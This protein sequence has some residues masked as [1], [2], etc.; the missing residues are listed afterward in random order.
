MRVVT[1]E[2]RHLDLVPGARLDGAMLRDLVLDGVDLSGSSLRGTF[3]NESWLVGANLAGSDLSGA[4]FYGADLRG[5]DLSDCRLD[6][7][8]W[9]EATWSASTRWPD[10]SPPGPMTDPLSRE[11]LG[12]EC[13]EDDSGLPRFVLFDER[14]VLGTV[15]WPRSIAEGIAAG[16]RCTRADQAEVFFRMAYNVLAAL[17]LRS[18]LSGSPLIPGFM[19]GYRSPFMD[20][21]AVDDEPRWI[22]YELEAALG[23]CVLALAALGLRVVRANVDGSLD[24]TFEPVGDM[25]SWLRDGRF[26][27]FEVL[28]RRALDQQFGAPLGAWSEPVLEMDAEYLAELNLDS[29]FDADEDELEEADDEEVP[30]GELVDGPDDVDPDAPP[31]E[32]WSDLFFSEFLPW[33]TIREMVDH[34]HDDE[35]V[36]SSW[37]RV[38]EALGGGALAVDGDP[39]RS[40]RTVLAAYLRAASAWHQVDGLLSRLDEEDMSVVDDE[41]EDEDDD[42][43]AANRFVDDIIN[44]LGIESI[45]RGRSGV[46]TAKLRPPMNVRGVLGEASSGVGSTAEIRNPLGE[47]YVVLMP[48]LGHF[49]HIIGL[50]SHPV[51][52]GGGQPSVKVVREVES[53][54]RGGEGPDDGSGTSWW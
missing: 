34:L 42:I 27:L 3:F 36:T 19:V 47:G 33:W 43:D 14:D 40:L 26:G 6:G 11:L 54:E 23:H 18:G 15:Q 7:C 41:V 20:G 21:E 45:S 12:D 8:Y 17:D 31:P 50:S 51:H 9:N 1:I 2:G 39:V 32:V 13:G 25:A 30:A 24:V 35:A 46:I 28:S 44:L 53:S 22:T 5:A 38:D 10:G 52:T 29:E 4:N 48:S 49:E 16:R 37:Q